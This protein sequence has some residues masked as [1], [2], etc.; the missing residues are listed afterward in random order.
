[1]PQGEPRRAEARVGP[2]SGR[3]PLCRRCVSPPGPGGA[4]RARS[5]AGG[6]RRQA[7]GLWSRRRRPPGQVATTT[8]F[9]LTACC[10]WA[11]M[12]RHLRDRPTRR[13]REPREARRAPR[14]LA[15]TAC[16]DRASEA[17]GPGQRPGQ[18]E[19]AARWCACRALGCSA[20]CGEVQHGEFTA[21]APTASRGACR[22]ARGGHL[23]ERTSLAVRSADGF[24]QTYAVN[25]ATR[26]PAARPPTSW[27]ATTWW[28]LARKERPR[29]PCRSSSCAGWR[30]RAAWAGRTTRAERRCFCH[31]RYPSGE[32]WV[33]AHGGQ[34]VTVVEVGGGLRATAPG[35]SRS[36]P[37]TARSSAARG[38]GRCSCP[39]PTGSGTAATPSTAEDHQLALTEPARGHASH[40]LVRWA[41]GRG[42]AGEYESPSATGCTPSPAGRA[43]S[44]SR[45]TYAL[46]DAG[47]SVLTT[48]T[49]IGDE[50]VPFGCG[51][52]PYI[53]IGDT[54]PRRRRPHGAR[55]RT[56]SR[57]RPAD[58]HRHRPG[59]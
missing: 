59:E 33:I 7:R 20:R 55:R 16:R 26:V 54:A 14:G 41:P 52:H 19:Q 24:A 44:T 31:A 15:A 21:T 35:A 23:G 40:G 48:A 13:P 36:S 32:Q 18:R 43:R 10:C 34:E 42:R 49:N 25:T 2:P 27:P 57:R 28:S 47:L 51:A 8:A 38:R 5:H 22:S 12:A 9:G 4:A 1:M 45:V 17:M 6:A 29:R 50:R 3:Q 37:A 11:R 39:G 46:S 58:P 56:G 53:A 30:D